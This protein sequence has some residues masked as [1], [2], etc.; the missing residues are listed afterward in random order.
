MLR[1]AD[2]QG[3]STKLAPKSSGPWVLLEC[4]ENGKAY[5]MRERVPGLVRQ[6]PQ[7]KL[8]VLE[9]RDEPGARPGEELPKWVAPWTGSWNLPFA[10]TSTAQPQALNPETN[11]TGAELAA[12]EPLRQETPSLPDSVIEPTSGAGPLREGLRWIASRPDRAAPGGIFVPS[13]RGRR[14]VSRRGMH[15][16]RK[17]LKHI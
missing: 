4:F 13:R 12:Q 5:R 8:K 2:L 16:L 11:P 6:V 15:A 14:V 17:R 1:P 7:S 10:P 3:V 9:L